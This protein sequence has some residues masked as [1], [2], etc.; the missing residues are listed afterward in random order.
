M[1]G[2]IIIGLIFSIFNIITTVIICIQLIRI[3]ELFHNFNQSNQINSLEKA[4]LF[5]KNDLINYEEF[6]KIKNNI[7]NEKNGEKENN[8]K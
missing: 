3:K 5:Y 6:N 2:L 7:M 8:E 1:T 4:Y